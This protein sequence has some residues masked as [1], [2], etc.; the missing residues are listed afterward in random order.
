M[1]FSPGSQDNMS[2]KK[3]DVSPAKVESVF[4]AKFSALK[5]HNPCQWL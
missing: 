4:Q 2:H 5:Q 1:G 3:M